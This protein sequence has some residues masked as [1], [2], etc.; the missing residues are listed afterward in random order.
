MSEQSNPGAAGGRRRRRWPALAAVAI[1]AAFTGAA[2]TGAVGQWAPGWGHWHGPGFMRGP[3]T[4][5]QIE[6]RVDRGIRH[7]AIELDATPEQQEKLR[8]IAKSAV[9]DLVP[10]GE[11]ARAVRERAA[12][13]LL[14]PKIDRAAIEAFRAEQ[15]ALADA[16]SKRLAQALGDVAEVLT[17]EQRQKAHEFLRWRRGFMRG[18]HRG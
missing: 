7:A 14:Q 6:D 11:K 10:M 17:P 3:M 1:V 12:A 2:A 18:W 5:E 4:P 9:R 13:L 8:A 16:A 15:M